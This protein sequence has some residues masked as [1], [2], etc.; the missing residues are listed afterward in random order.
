[1]EG[2]FMSKK[3]KDL[4]PKP[5]P[6]AS[7]P[8]SSEPKKKAEPSASK[9]TAADIFRRLIATNPRF[10]EVK[11]KGYVFLGE[12]IYQQAKAS[13]ENASATALRPGEP[14]LGNLT[15]EEQSWVATTF[16]HLK[17]IY[18]AREMGRPGEEAFCI[19]EAGKTYVQFL[20][21]WDAEK[22]VCE[23]A[24]A[25]SVQ[26]IGAVLT[27]GGDEILRKMGFEPPEISP[28][29]SQ[30]IEIE[31]IN[32]LGYAARLALLPPRPEYRTLW[33]VQDLNLERSAIPAGS[34]FA[35]D[36]QCRGSRGLLATDES[37]EVPLF[38]KTSVVPGTCRWHRIFGTP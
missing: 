15:P 26:E 18:E 8:N 13:A 14:P 29:Y 27:M 19:F 28:N 3:P 35:R 34:Y 30:T 17:R 36:R 2:F 5:K 9:E 32:D 21:S 4:T 11:N 7:A 23:A 16:T 1:M 12:H 25:K 38:Y 10:K 37:E 24:S 20:A 31:G 6:S 22:L 33:N